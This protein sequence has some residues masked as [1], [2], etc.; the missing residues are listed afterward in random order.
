MSSEPPRIMDAGAISP[1]Q[2]RNSPC[3]CGS[4]QRYKNCHGL[5]AEAK[6]AVAANPSSPRLS[7][8]RAPA[9]EWPDVSEEEQDRLGVIMERALAHQLAERVDE[10]ARDYRTVLERAPDTHDAL[11]MLGVIELGRQNVDD[12]EQLIR[13]AMTLRSL[14]P[15]IVRNLKLVEDAKLT[16]RRESPELLCERALP[17]FADLALARSRRSA[18]GAVGVRA[19]EP[20]LGE[21]HLIGRV[22][23][24]LSDDCWL[25]R[26]LARMI[27]AR[28]WAV[29]AQGTGSMPRS[30]AFRVQAHRSSS[31]S[32]PRILPGSNMPL[33]NG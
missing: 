33:R 18:G 27:D 26:R 32:M 16:R 24:P 12:A 29:E 10:A 17:L 3:P 5:L 25:L 22:H 13:R 6:G 1:P 31:G 21:I 19:K 30:A 23:A 4:G 11:H 20:G 9:R 14:H 8:Y 15:A 28:V 2:S 7:S